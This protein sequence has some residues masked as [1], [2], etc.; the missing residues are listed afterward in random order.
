MGGVWL[1]KAERGARIKEFRKQKRMSQLRLADA[2]FVDQSAISR[3][4]QGKGP[5]PTLEFIQHLSEALSVDASKLLYAD[6]DS[7]LEQDI[8]DA[9][10]ILRNLPRRERKTIM[11]MLYG[12]R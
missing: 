6:S 2:L 7:E 10:E 11:K 5:D 8:E 12:F 3:M 4:E 1:T 9:T